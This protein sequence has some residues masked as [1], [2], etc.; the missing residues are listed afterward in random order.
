MPTDIQLDR[1]GL[2][3]IDDDE[4]LRLLAS[5]KIGRVG[6]TTDAMPLVLPVTFA[7][8]GRRVVFCS[9]PGT[10]LYLALENATVAFEADDVDPDLRFGW[11]VCLTGPARVLRDEADVDRARRL[12]LQLWANLRDPAYVAID[13]QV[14]TGR[15]VRR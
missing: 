14:I 15:R 7:L 3:I 6:M 1:N 8:D 2:E 9:T 12:G 13:A 5:V 11:S 4:C 10:K